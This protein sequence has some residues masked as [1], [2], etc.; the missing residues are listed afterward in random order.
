ME[1]WE[2]LSNFGY[3]IKMTFI[4]IFKVSQNLFPKDKFKNAFLSTTV[5][6]AIIKPTK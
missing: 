1:L 4:I 6:T 5:T 2:E 3:F